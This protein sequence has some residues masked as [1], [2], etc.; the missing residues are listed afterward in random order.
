MKV[1]VKKE[2]VKKRNGGLWVEVTYLV[3]D[4]VVMDDHYN[5]S[6]SP[7]FIN[8]MIEKDRLNIELNLNDLN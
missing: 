6:N 3:N 5:L 7:K 8:D 1:A 4:E 2:L